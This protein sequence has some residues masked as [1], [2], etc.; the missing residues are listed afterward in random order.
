MPGNSWVARTE[1]Y[2]RENRLMEDGDRLIVGVSGGA[3]SVCLLEVLCELAPARQ[4]ELRVV[5]VH[6]GLRGKSADEDEKFVQ[7]LCRGKGI[8]CRSVRVDVP[9]EAGERGIG[10]EECGR[11]LRR[12]IFEE[13]LVRE[14][15]D[16]I[17]LAHHRDD[18][19]ETMIFNLCRGTGIRG[20][21]GI[22]P[23][24]GLYVRPLL[25]SSRDQIEAF[26]AERGLAYREDETNAQL[27]YQRNR[28][29][30]EVIP[31]LQERVN[32]RASE[33]IDRAAAELR[34]I[35]D[36]L[37]S[38]TDKLAAAYVTKND[39]SR[40]IG[41]DLRLE[42]EVLVARLLQRVL[43]EAAGGAHDIGNVH[44]DAV[45][46]L[47]YK[48][49]GKSLDLPGGV[50]CLRTAHALSIHPAGKQTISQPVRYAFTSR[51]IGSD[52][53]PDLAGDPY[54]KYFDYDIIGE[55]SVWRTRENGDYL[56]VNAD[57]GRQKLGDWFTDHKIPAD[58]RDQI[59]LLADGHH[60]YWIVG[61]R[62]AQDCLITD[63]TETIIEWR[64]ERI[65]G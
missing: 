35:D 12:K 14:Q 50:V 17:V 13:E 19:V 18:S 11:I 41:E 57:G 55:N 21:A 8:P 45:R 25:W 15:A 29:R 1:A 63:G 26:A 61:Y 42:P 49:A 28:I 62:Q 52:E 36:Y 48:P 43:T 51:I 56:V 60:V 4:W 59:M 22:K 64:A 10:A 34:R 54:T 37:E 53:S 32:A 33:H 30:H 5:H 7:D 6:H 20:L 16:R 38:E 31:L 27:V 65:N 24:D 23:D 46:A 9:A 40:L 47:L 58:E 44:I 3:D 2:I 39:D